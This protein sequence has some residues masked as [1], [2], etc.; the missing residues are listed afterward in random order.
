MGNM[1]ISSTLA[2]S[3]HMFS[4][5]QQWSRPEVKLGFLCLLRAALAFLP[6]F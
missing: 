3:L 6:C 4:E 5:E 2:F 1:N